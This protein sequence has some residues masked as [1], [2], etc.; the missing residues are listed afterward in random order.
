MSSN[1]EGMSNIAGG[2]QA[3]NPTQEERRL[4]ALREMQL[5]R[6]RLELKQNNGLVFYSPHS[7]Q[8]RF[9]R[10]GNFKHRMVRCGNRYGK[11]TLGCAEDLAWML[12]ERPWYRKDDPARTAGIPQ[13]PNKGLVITTDW[14]KVNEI[15]TS[16]RGIG[17]SVGKIWQFAPRGYIKHTRRNHS[18]AIEELVGENGSILRFDTVESFKKNQQGQES[19]DWD[20]IHVDEPCPEAMYKAAARGLMDRNGSDWFTLTPLA[21]FWINDMFFPRSGANAQFRAGTVWAQTGNTKDNP[22]LT[23]QSIDDYV[24]LLSPDEV[25]CRLKGIPLEL[26]GLVYKN[27]NFSKH[28]LQELPKGWA[29]YDDPPKNYICYAAI[30][31]H[32][33]TPM[34]VLFVAVAPTGQ[35]FIYDEIWSKCSVEELAKLVLWKLE[36]RNCSI[37]KCEPA[38]WIDDPIT[39]SSIAMELGNHGLFVDKASKAK[40]FG[41]LKMNAEFAKENNV[42]VSPQVH[43]FL[44]E[45]HRYCFDKENK[46][47]DR[48]DHMMEN[49]Y[50]LFVNDPIWYNPDTANY[51]ITDNDMAISKPEFT[52]D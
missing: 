4:A 26:S 7:G 39:G 41:V 40:S 12:G 1:R 38:A 34:A 49:M 5:L 46:P 47:V 51:P 35:K 33:Q 2:V 8:D 6:K 21:E 30:D 17:T 27:F 19:S 16:Q 50:R 48:D 18:G 28:V 24:A 42:Y 22:H 52:L 14:D 20:F 9:H 25:E 23:K 37:P 11:S 3:L 13:R 43:R 29:S 15:W 44:F 36:G 10:A 31:T 32:P 45:I